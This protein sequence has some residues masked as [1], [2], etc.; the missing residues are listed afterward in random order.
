MT[1]YFDQIDQVKY[2][3]AQSTNPFAYRFYDANRVVLGKTMAEH[4]RLAVC[5][6]HTFCW[7]GTDMFGTASLDRPWQKKSDRIGSGKRK[8]K[9]CI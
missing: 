6:W 1:T 2:E 5:Y 7:N 9:Y 3:G 8:S 4:L